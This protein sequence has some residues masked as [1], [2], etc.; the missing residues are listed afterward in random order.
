MN[1]VMLVGRLVRDPNSFN[2]STG[3]KYVRF[4]IAV[5]RSY[6]KEQTDFV[7]VVAWRQSADFVSNYLKKGDLVS[8]EGAFTSSTY[9]KDDE[10]MVTKYEVTVDRIQSLQSKRDAESYRSNE[11][12]ALTNIK[13]EIDDKKDTK[14]KKKSGIPS[15]TSG[16]NDVPW[17]IE[18]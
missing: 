8:V 10:Q 15:F 16:N 3:I 7:P 2:T 17:D 4:T 18:I 5:A 9:K 6:N 1:K 12:E 13:F 14:T 11:T